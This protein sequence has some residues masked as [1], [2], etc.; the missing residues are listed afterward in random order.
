MLT[1]I[2]SNTHIVDVK[3]PQG[4]NA[5]IF[6]IKDFR[7]LFA[8]PSIFLIKDSGSAK[9]MQS[10]LSDF[11]Y[12]LNFNILSF[13]YDKANSQKYLR[14]KHIFCSKRMTII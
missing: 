10:V 5:P 8:H 11:I 13:W 1:F 3:Y 9:I 6:V 12:W 7:G 14:L 2:L 4:I